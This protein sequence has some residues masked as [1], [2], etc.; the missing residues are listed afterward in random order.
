VVRR[1]AP[2]EEDC[3]F[4]WIVLGG[5]RGE[6]SDRSGRNDKVGLNEIRRR[7]YRPQLAGGAFPIMTMTGGV[8]GFQ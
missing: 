8:F 6:D 3:C 1:R 4:C 2:R 5:P 7:K